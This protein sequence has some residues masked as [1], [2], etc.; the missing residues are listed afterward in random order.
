MRDALSREA[1]LSRLTTHVIG[2]SLEVHERIDSTNARAVA[3]ARSGAPDGTLVLAEWQHEG[4]GRLGRRWFSPPG[5]SLLMS[6][7]LRP[8]L[9]P[10]QAQRATMI[11]SLA[12]VEA[13]AQVTGLTAQL[14][15]PNDITVGDRK[16]GGVLTELGLEGRQLTYVV[17]GMGL[18]VDLDVSAL[19]EIMAP[20]TS[21][22]KELGHR[23]S[24]VDLLIAVLREVEVRYD[25]LAAGW[26]PHSEWRDHLA[27]LGQ[28][29]QVRSCGSLVEGTAEDVDADG[30][31]LVRTDRGELRSVVVG[32]A[33]LRGQLPPT[34]PAESCD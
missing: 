22:L 17:V 9:A 20:A 25:R 19:P 1:I 16:L 29:V 2:R 6:L 14:K 13:I 5:S 34:A 18:N 7:V 8:C 24:R 4:R 28:R 23:V 10:R 15:W 26:S 30:A 27:T 12:A 31:L 21:L 11:C 32:D 33:T 3:L